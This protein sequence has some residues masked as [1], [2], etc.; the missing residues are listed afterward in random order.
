MKILSTI[1]VHQVSF[2]MMKKIFIVSSSY[3][4]VVHELLLSVGLVHFPTFF[5][6]S[7]SPV[8]SGWDLYCIRGL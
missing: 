1:N 6:H 2:I 4:A 3:R 8:S 7:P 5:S